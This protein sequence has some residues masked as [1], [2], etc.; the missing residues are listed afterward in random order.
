M[1]I[2]SQAEWLYPA[3]V[4]LVAY[5][6]LGVTGF[7]SALVAVPL[8]SWIW[9]LPQVVA[10]VVSLDIVSSILH[11]RMNAAH[12]QWK[13]LLR[14]VPGVL[15]GVVLAALLSR[16]LGSRWPLLALG[17]YI[18]GIG[19]RALRHPPQPQHVASPRHAA[20]TD[21]AVGVVVGAI[22]LLFGTAGPPVV[23]W[24]SRRLGNARLVRATA[25]VAMVFASLIALA[26]MAAD[27]R[28]NTALHWQRF[29][30]LLALAL[31]AVAGG[32]RLA[33]TLPADRLRRLVCVLLVASG[34]ALA[35]RA[36][37]S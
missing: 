2:A 21:L 33:M 30:A 25:P 18:A 26:G 32:H 29:G 15:I 35:V 3:M 16:W 14:L 37:T 34:L 28:L 27:G 10:L 23:A 4:I 31:I 7:G 11:G 22:E 13:T 24:L 20:A 36:V 19:L 12:V 5:T 9:P 17:F 6:V 1:S 8:L